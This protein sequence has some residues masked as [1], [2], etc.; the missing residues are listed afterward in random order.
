MT[1]EFRKEMCLEQV[2]MKINLM[3]KFAKEGSAACASILFHETDGMIDG[4]FFA[5]VITDT[6]F[7]NL[8]DALR[9]WYD[10][11]GSWSGRLFK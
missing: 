4:L 2:T 1:K 6:E 7:E 8:S 11:P 9:I 3:V 10:A 5:D